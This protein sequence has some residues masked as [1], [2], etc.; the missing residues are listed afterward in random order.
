MLQITLPSVELWDETRDLFIYTKEVTIRLEHSLVSV[1]KWESTWHKPFLSD[2]KKTNEEMLDYI[3]CMTITQNVDPSAYLTIPRDKFKEIMDYIDDSRSATVFYDYDGNKM[4]RRK[5]RITS[6]KIYSWMVTL[7]IPFECQTWHINRLMNLIRY[8][9]AANQ[10]PKKRS[11][12]ELVK[13]YA[14]I[15]AANKKRFNTAG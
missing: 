11:A 7:G 15:N 10:P 14:R 13:E 2:E 3:R 5:E 1:S 4:P 9:N 12:G 8:C 6:E